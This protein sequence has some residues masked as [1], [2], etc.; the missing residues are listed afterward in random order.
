M[1]TADR[2]LRASFIVTCGALAA[3]LALHVLSPE[4]APAW[5]MVSE[6]ALG[7]YGVVL[8]LFF[9]CWACGTWLLAWGL[10]PRVRG[11]AAK[12]GVWLLILSGVGE[13]LGGIFDVRQE[14][15]HGLA[16]LLGVPSLPIAAL[17][18]GMHLGRST[19]YAQHKKLLM[20]TSQLPWVSL[21][22]MAAAMAVMMH[23]F[24]QA[25][26]PPRT[27]PDALP[28]NV[29]AFGGWANR[30]LIVAYCTWLLVVG[31]VLRSTH[32]QERP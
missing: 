29:I 13:F 17:L 25:G 7:N 19:K 23:G 26:I 32:D 14:G 9:F 10:W 5:R 2:A 24:A 31:K 12:L 8:T 11:I 4:L 18:V 15:L 21:V 20:W 6:Y 3:L 30:F 16:F 22:L 28:P 1:N 27:V